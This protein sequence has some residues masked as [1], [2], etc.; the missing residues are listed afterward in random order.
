M[1]GQPV[2]VAL[3]RLQD[4]DIIRA[5]V[6][7]PRRRDGIVEAE[8]RCRRG[9]RRGCGR[10]RSRWPSRR[11]GCGSARRGRDAGGRRLR[12][13]RGALRGTASAQ[14][15]DARDENAPCP[16][17]HVCTLGNTDQFGPSEVCGEKFAARV[18]DLPLCPYFRESR[19][20]QRPHQGE[21]WSKDRVP[22]LRRAWP[23]V[24]GCCYSCALCGWPWPVA[25][26]VCL[27]TTTLSTTTLGD[28]RQGLGP[29]F[30][31][32][33]TD[34]CSSAERIRP[35]VPSGCGGGSDARGNSCEEDCCPCR[36]CYWWA[37]CCFACRWCRFGSSLTL[38]P[39]PCRLSPD[40]SVCAD[41]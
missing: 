19:L 4:R 23:E 24:W 10:R 16:L 40:P 36:C 8:V 39:R 12:R 29:G 11:R 33:S 27:G 30:Y 5:G 14:G 25:T 31:F 38:R 32:T 20:A 18:S 22:S 21:N 7:E 34:V 26:G 2:A 41:I 9:R 6:D 28:R 13:C 35:V 1:G 15:D 17:P 3:E 37:C